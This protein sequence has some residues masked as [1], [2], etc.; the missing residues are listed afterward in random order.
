MAP[1][2]EDAVRAVITTIDHAWRN[3]QFDGLNDCFHPDA[4]ITGPDHVEYARGREKCAESYREF[5][6]NAAVLSY[7]ETDHVLRIWET[8]A[9]YTFAWQMVYQREKGPQREA[10]TDQLVLQCNAGRWQVVWR[11]IYFA[12]N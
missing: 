3:K 6:S 2:S 12:A 5:A 9:V 7:T 1:S 10:G 8:T 4:I 11:H